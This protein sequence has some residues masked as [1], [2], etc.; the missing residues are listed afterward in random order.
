MPSGTASA[1]SISFDG[2]TN[3][4]IYRSGT[5]QLSFTTAGSER[6]R[7]TSAG[8]V[9][10]GTSSPFTILHSV[11]SITGGNPATSGTTDANVI[12]RFQ[13][14]SVGLDIGGTASGA[15]WIQPRSVNN[16]AT[17]YGLLLCPNGG[18]VG[19]GT[20]SPNA[21]LCVNG[22][23]PQ[24]GIISAVAASGGR[25]LALSDNIN[26][27]LYVTHL[28][29]GVVIGTDSGNAIRFATNGFGSSDEKARIDSSGRLLIGTSSARSNFFNSTLSSAVHVESASNSGR[30][31]SLVNNGAGGGTG[32]GIILGS[33]AGANGLAVGELGIISFQGNDGTEFVEGARIEAI[34]DGTSSAND[35]PSRLVFST[36]ADG[37]SSPTER[38][39][40]TNDG[41][42]CYDQAAPVSYAAAATLV[43]GDLKNGLV[44]YTG[45]AATLTLPTGTLT[46]GGFAANSLYTNITFEWSVINTGSGTCTV[47]NG[48]G[49]TVTGS[50]TVAAGASGR[51]ASRRT[52][53]NTFVSYRLS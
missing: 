14:G 36:T 44:Q 37:A 4:G 43:V 10:I 11:I 33:S 2:D 28:A 6:L 17:N 12:A 3:L 46:E 26:C 22:L 30:F 8:L 45:A 18:N 40:I 7:I 9:G 13:G 39:R 51:F 5:D 31:L 35:M 20:T 25:S 19:I 29:G 41:V 21:P 52:A 53:A 42:M 38:M 24:A 32:G 34:V 48:T 27:S 23:P 16:F 15:Q 1:P 50:A 49:H 47:G